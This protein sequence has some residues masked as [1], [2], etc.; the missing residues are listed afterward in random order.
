VVDLL[1]EQ[2]EWEQKEMACYMLENSPREDEAS[3]VFLQLQDYL[4][5]FVRVSKQIKK[6]IVE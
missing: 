2:D 1:L 3:S 5:N 6:L 4:T